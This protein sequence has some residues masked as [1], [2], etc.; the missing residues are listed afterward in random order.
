MLLST[1][2]LPHY[3]TQTH[4]YSYH[5]TPTQL[6]CLTSTYWAVAAHLSLTNRAL[7]PSPCP[8]NHH[9]HTPNPIPPPNTVKQ[10]D[11]TRSVSKMYASNA[12]TIDGINTI[13]LQIARTHTNPSIPPNGPRTKLMGHSLVLRLRKGQHHSCLTLSK[14]TA[15][16]MI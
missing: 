5:T 14:Y 16:R 4:A 3:P 11:L 9:P 2:H 1:N 12:A 10:L 7:S 6:S 8:S 13:V 15:S